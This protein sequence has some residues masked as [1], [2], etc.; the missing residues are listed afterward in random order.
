[1]TWTKLGDSFGDDCAHAKLSDAAFRTHVEGLM[2]TMRR[3]TD[4]FL[5]Y[6][7]VRR[8]AETP[9]PDAAIT[10]LIAAEFWA[11]TDGGYQVIAHM[12]DQPSAEL[13][14]RRREAAAERK[15]RHELHVAEIHTKC[16]PK[17]CAVARERRSGTR[18]E[19]RDPGRVGT[20]RGTTNY[21]PTEAE[22]PSPD[23]SS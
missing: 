16:L 1:M 21:S 22:E 11:L 2:W 4:G 8:F 9:D 7:D 3:E 5:D 15:E 10:E 13:I 6:R 14:H 18:S 23:G 12:T 17:N 20:V 19:T